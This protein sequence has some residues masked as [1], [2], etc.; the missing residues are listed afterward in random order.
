[1]SGVAAEPEDDAVAIERMLDDGAPTTLPPRVR[2]RGSRWTPL[3]LTNEAPAEERAAQRRAA[4]HVLRL[5][6]F[7]C[8]RSSEVAIAPVRPGR[9]L[10]CGGTMIVEVAATD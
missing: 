8:G 4:R 3:Q 7:S 1:M 9:C 5:Y 10:H 6:C 2:V